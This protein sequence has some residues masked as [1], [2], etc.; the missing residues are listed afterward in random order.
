MKTLARHALIFAVVGIL[1]PSLAEAQMVK[2]VAIKVDVK[3]D[4][5]K[6]GV[7]GSGVETTQQKKL[8][9]NLTNQGPKELPKLSV[10]YF[11]FGKGGDEKD[12]APSISDRGEHEVKLAPMGKAKIETEEA[13]FTFIRRH[14]EKAGNSMVT[15]PASG[16]K[17]VG[18]A[19]QVWDGDKLV[20]EDVNPVELRPVLQAETKEKE[21][22]KDK[23]AGKK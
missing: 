5:G 16:E 22:E 2:P 20:A 19:V 18:Y 21:K 12:K 11:F 3:S 7:G 14:T 8:E 10:R 13:K 17:Y 1:L 6:K 9:I 15:V 4:T 23:D